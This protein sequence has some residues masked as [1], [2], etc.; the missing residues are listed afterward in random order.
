MP[1]PR[2][3][4]VLLIEDNRA[5]AALVRAL[6]HQLPGSPFSLTIAESLATAVEVLQARGADVILLDL[7]L[8]DSAG[9]A[10]LSTV[11]D[12]APDL[13]VVVLTGHDDDRAALEALKHGAQDY[14]VKGRGDGTVLRRVLHYAIERKQAAVAL[15]ESEARFRDYAASSS[16]WFWETDVRF[17]YTYVSDRFQLL[18]G[19]A[20]GWLLGKAW[21]ETLA[22]AAAPDAASEAVL[23]RQPFRDVEVDLALPNGSLLRVSVSGVPVH[24][25]RGG[26]LGYRGTA[27]DVTEQH[28]MREALQEA[29]DRAEEGARAKSS[30]LATMGHEV[31]TPLHG[32][33]GMAQLLLGERLEARQRERV[34]VIADSGEQLL[35]VLDDI[36]DFTRMEA[37]R[38]PLQVRPFSLPALLAAA[39]G[40]MAPLA[41][42]KGIELDTR[43]AAGLGSW[44]SGDPVRLRQILINL[45]SN[46]IKFTERGRVVVSVGPGRRA[47]R[48]E[49]SDTG[50][51]IAHQHQGRLFSDFSRIAAASSRTRAGSGLGLAICKRLVTLMGGEIGLNSDPGVGST[52]WVELPL[53]PAVEQPSPPCG[54]ATPPPPPRLPPRSRRILLVEDHEV[55]RSVATQT[56]ERAGHAVVAVADGHSALDALAQHPFDVVL[57]D[58]ML[59][60]M[61]GE[62][63]ARRMRGEETAGRMR[64]GG[65]LPILAFTAHPEAQTR[66]RQMGF[67]GFIAKPLRPDTLEAA[68]HHAAAPPLFDAAELTADIDLLGVAEVGKLLTLFE[69]SATADLTRLRALLAAGNYEDA[70]MHAH[71]LGSASASMHLPALSAC[72]R[73]VEHSTVERQPAAARAALAEAEAL[74]PESLAMVRGAM[75][76]RPAAQPTTMR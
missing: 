62:E 73:R 52:F 5:D 21:R 6:L 20:P 53:Q 7:A 54:V 18:T 49:V 43:F 9:V 47:V 32:I 39:T 31:K 71:R 17:R 37:G 76:P 33:L 1:E 67:D 50:I 64:G 42:G 57:L 28:R 29:K 56:L 34:R 40:L 10:T 24:A 70:A 41:A 61:D 25:P 74:W 72:F 3:V 51:G 59:P 26:F 45:L 16:D 4:R 38:L 46:A 30:F 15:R 44:W 27:S 55:N 8:P 22:P 68:L 58:L 69:D 48:I 19:A 2:Q 66:W 12:M 65:A 23:R 35:A 60:G 63:T 13:A 11:Q 75:K 14:L 36:L